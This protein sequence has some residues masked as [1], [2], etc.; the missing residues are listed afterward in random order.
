MAIM[1]QS[2][3]MTV[4]YRPIVSHDPARPAEAAPVAGSDYLWFDRAERLS[5][6]GD[7]AIVAAKDVP[8]GVLH[9]LTA[10]RPSVAGVSMDVPS[11]MGIVNVTP[12]S[13]SDGGRHNDA[14]RAVAHAQLLLEEGADF[15]DIGGEST[16]P[17]AEFVPDEE[18]IRRTAPVIAR[19]TAAG[20]SAIS[21]DTRK[22][23]VARAAILDGATVLNDVSG[24]D[25]DPAMADLCV[26]FDLPICVM[27][28]QGTPETMQND[29]RYSDVVLD[30]YDA[31]EN[32][33]DRLVNLGLDR[34]K[35]IVDPGIGFGKTQAHNLALLQNISIF[36][37]LGCPI[38]L[39]VSRK[40]FI[41]TI[42]NAPEADKRA[43]GS[44]AVAMAAVAQGIQILR[45]HDVSETKQ[46]L[47]LHLAVTR[48]HF[49]VA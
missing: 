43:P 42:G 9:R 31:L 36:H 26:E 28:A 12:D 44:I 8:A 33:V 1:A 39:G 25:F 14:E 20:L 32:K 17:G 16:R 6:D 46:A 23:M 5:R 47:D 41:G 45:V 48:G 40:R 13:F 35:I 29:P 30:V 3:A 34:G 21:I 15:L 2:Q 18:E 38:L 27:H 10:P 22:S 19:L 4:Y 11:I 7:R 24:L 49:D 37:G